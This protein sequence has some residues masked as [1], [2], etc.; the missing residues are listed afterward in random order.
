MPYLDV[1][2]TGP[3]GFTLRAEMLVDSGGEESCLP[4]QWAELLQLPALEGLRDFGGIDGKTHS[5][6]A[7]R[8]QVNFGRRMALMSPLR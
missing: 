3:T 1:V 7:G 2:L 8:V 4:L 6:R 5:A